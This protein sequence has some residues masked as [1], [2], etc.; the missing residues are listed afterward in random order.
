MVGVVGVV[1]LCNPPEP[2]VLLLRPRLRTHTM[3]EYV[4]QWTRLKREFVSPVTAAR[5]T[6]GI[7][8]R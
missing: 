3:V 7:P 5:S 1:E 6:Q 8:G 4:D 2:E